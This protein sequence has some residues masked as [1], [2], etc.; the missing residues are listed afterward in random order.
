METLSK[1]LPVSFAVSFCATVLA[2]FMRLQHSP[3]ASNFM[4]VG[5]LFAVIFMVMAV[6][7]IWNTDRVKDNNRVFW[8]LAVV[9]FGTLGGL[10]YFMIG[11]RKS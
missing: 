5:L 7:E 3:F 6:V 4:I 9:L 2:A 10:L 8:T 1:I 11:R